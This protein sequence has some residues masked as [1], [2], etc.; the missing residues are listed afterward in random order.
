ML[1]SRLKLNGDKTE[2]LVIG[3][4]KQCA[5]LSNLFVNI[6][7]ST[8]EPNEKARNLGV[9][10]DANLPLKSPVN[11]L[12]SSARYYLHNIR[13]ARKYLTQEAAEKAIHAFVTSRLD[14]NNSLLYGLPMCELKKLQ[15]VQY[16]AARILTRAKRDSHVTLVLKQLHW[17]PISCRIK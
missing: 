17:L 6:G 16:T 14:C 12:C 7:N 5:K 9:V 2:L 4:R 11:S 10:F 13:L 1:T 15:K 8:I 3:T